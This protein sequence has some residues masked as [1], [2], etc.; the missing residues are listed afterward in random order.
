M[1]CDRIIDKARQIAAHHLEAAHEDLEF[2]QG[3]F[4]VQG[5][6]EKALPLAAIAFEAFT[7]HNLPEGMSGS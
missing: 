7:A 6:P 4:S 2:A 3:S 5:T 1:A